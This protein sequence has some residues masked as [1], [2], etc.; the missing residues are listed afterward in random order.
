VA[1]RATAEIERIEATGAQVLVFDLSGVS[2]LD[3]TGMGVI[4]AAHGRAEEAC[5]RFAVVGPPPRSR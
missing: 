4:A 1:D 2:F 5:R 3:S